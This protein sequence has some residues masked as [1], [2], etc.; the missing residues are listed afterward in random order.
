L[1]QKKGARNDKIKAIH[2]RGKEFKT[3]LKKEFQTEFEKMSCEIWTEKLDAYLDGELAP[4]EAQAIDAHLRTCPGCAAEGLSRMQMKRALQIAARK[5]APDPAFRARVQKS[6]ARQPGS[7]SRLWVFAF[8]A[9]MIVL[10][11][12]IF[13]LGFSRD[14]ARSG[15]LLSQLADVHVAT[16]SSSNP[17]DVVSTDRHTVK[18]WFE[19]KLPFTFNL[20]ELQDTA[21]TLVGGKVTYLN[22]SPG[23]ELLFRVRQ[24][25]LSVFIFQERA[26]QGARVPG[27]ATAQSFNLRSWSHNG[28]CYFIIGDVGAPDIDKLADLLKSAG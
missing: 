3:E 8:A 14:R 20:P 2:L 28:L 9:A 22:Q 27:S 23:A 10:V 18:P 15:Q 12:G 21:F 26:L 11:A 1:R 16:L 13:F 6:I 25:Q 24:H 19:G 5:F 4:A 17:I 7:R